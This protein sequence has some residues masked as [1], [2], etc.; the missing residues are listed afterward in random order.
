MKKYLFAFTAIVLAVVFS[1]FTKPFANKT[2]RLKAGVD[3]TSPTQVAL[4]SNWEEATLSCTGSADIPCTITVDE[5]FTSIV[6]GDRVLNTS[7]SF[8]TIQ[9]ENGLLDTAP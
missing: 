5:S 3:K 7:G 4:K 1:S 2:F 6:N 9:T 8:I